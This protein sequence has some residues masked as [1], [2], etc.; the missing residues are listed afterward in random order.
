MLFRSGATLI[1]GATDAYKAYKSDNAEEKQA[2]GAS[3]ALKFGGVAGGAAIGTLILPGIGTAIGAG[4][5]GIAGWLGGNKMKEGYQEVQEEAEKAQKA[6][7]ATGL[8]IEDITFKNGALAQAL[9][10]SEVSAS[11]FAMMYKEACE[12]VAKGAFGNISLSLAEVKKLAGEIGR[13][14]CRERV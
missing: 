2:Y 3:A 12:D 6:F 8:A 9:E 4:I 10:D 11:Q 5:G 14:S 13:A 7:E 1:S